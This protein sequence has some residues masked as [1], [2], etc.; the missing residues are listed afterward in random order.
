MA[1]VDAIVYLGLLVYSRAEPLH[2]CQEPDGVVLGSREVSDGV[3]VGTLLDLDGIAAEDALLDIGAGRQD[4]GYLLV[5]C[6]EE[7]GHESGGD[8][9]DE[10]L[11]GAAG[12][13]HGVIGAVMRDLVGDDSR[14]F[15]DGLRVFYQAAMNVNEAAGDATGVDFIAIEHL[16]GVL[17]VGP[18]GVGNEFD[19]NVL[20]QLA[21]VLVVPQLVLF[22]YLRG[23]LDTDSLLLFL[24][25]LLGASDV[26]VEDHRRR[27][28]QYE[29]SS[30]LHPAVSVFR[31]SLRIYFDVTRGQLF[32]T[33]ENLGTEPCRDV[34]ELVTNGT[35]YSPGERP[36]ASRAIS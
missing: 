29:I 30:W 27:E 12:L 32:Q 16:H 20:D 24:R 9:P 10:E 15:V 33:P 31:H 8:T 7:Y 14:E 35:T 4:A 3:E 19:E 2:E 17:E 6:A 13:V 11:L 18:V 5:G 25:P 1:L 22:L 23:D 26:D 21:A 34:L 36:A 28:Y